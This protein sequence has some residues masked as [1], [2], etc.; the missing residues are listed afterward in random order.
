M[1]RLNVLDNYVIM[2]I[3]TAVLTDKFDKYNLSNANFSNLI[4][5]LKKPI[6]IEV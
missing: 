6:I 2:L 5:T 4:L 3:N 1:Q